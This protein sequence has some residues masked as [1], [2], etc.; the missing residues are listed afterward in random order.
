[1]SVKL[2]HNCG[3]PQFGV[4]FPQ[5]LCCGCGCGVHFL[6]IVVDVGVVVVKSKNCGWGDSFG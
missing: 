5:K 2:W 4:V 3:E 6:N 1:M